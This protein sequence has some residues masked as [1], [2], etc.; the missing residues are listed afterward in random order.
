M[1]FPLNKKLL[2]FIPNRFRTISYLVSIV[3]IIV[4]FLVYYYDF[5]IDFLSTS[6]KASGPHHNLTDEVALSFLL[7]S[8]LSIVF[9]KEK[10]EDEFFNQIR[11]QSFFKAIGL[12]TLVQIIMIWV[13]YD[14]KFLDYSLINLFLPLLF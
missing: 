10:K 11:L 5:N 12:Y 6:N 2:V 13:L 9:S 7:L 3:S 14:E 8:L 4:L 1:L